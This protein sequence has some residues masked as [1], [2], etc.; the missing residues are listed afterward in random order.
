MRF[1]CLQRWHKST[2]TFHVTCICAL[3][4]RWTL[5]TSY[6]ISEA[7]FNAAQHQRRSNS[8]REWP[9]NNQGLASVLRDGHVYRPLCYV[10]SEL[11]ELW[12]RP[13][14]EYGSRNRTVV[15][16]RFGIK[17]NCTFTGLAAETFAIA[18]LKL[19]VYRR[20]RQ[21]AVMQLN[22]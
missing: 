15:A 21:K 1:P 3:P 16:C 22:S 4:L 9:E 10:L 20:R 13:K 11:K 6:V 18:Q 17:F 8:K 2:T 5:S 19:L 7:L 14:S 12:G